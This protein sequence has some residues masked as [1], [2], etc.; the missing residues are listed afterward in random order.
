MNMNHRTAKNNC[1]RK[2]K[3][4]KL[5]K[6]KTRHVESA[7]LAVTREAKS[8]ATTMRARVPR[9]VNHASK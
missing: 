3:N 4:I 7:L 5:Q 1:K 6:E 9:D 2:R 8:A